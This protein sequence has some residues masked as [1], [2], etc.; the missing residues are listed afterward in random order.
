MF[1]KK[2]AYVYVRLSP[3]EPHVVVGDYL[4]LTQRGYVMRTTD[5]R[6]TLASLETTRR[7]R[8]KAEVL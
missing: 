4:R 5:S 6:A 3:R 2:G 8:F 7:R 1:R